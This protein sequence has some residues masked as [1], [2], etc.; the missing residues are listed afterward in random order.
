MAKKRDR[1][2]FALT[3]SATAM[4]G[5]VVFYLFFVVQMVNAPDA[6]DGA[7]LLDFSAFWGAARLA[8]DGL[9]PAAYDFRLIQIA[10][11]VPPDST[12]Q[13]PWLYPPTAFLAVLPLGLLPFSAGFG[14]FV[15][16]SLTVW[17]RTMA[18]LGRG[19]RAGLLFVFATPTFAA[20]HIIGNNPA[21]WIGGLVFALL[22]LR[23]GRERSA[24][25][26]LAAMTLK[27]S[28]GLLIPVA[29]IAAGAWRAV[30]WA[31]GGALFLAAA[32]TAI[33]GVE[34][35]GAF[36]DTLALTQELLS[37]DAF[38]NGKMTTWHAAL[39]VL[40]A[41]A[42]TAAAAQ[43]AVTLALAGVVA[44]AWR[45]PG[46]CFD[47]RCALLLFAIPLSGPY[48]FHYETLAAIPGLVFLARAQGLATLE[49]RVFAVLVWVGLVPFLR[50][51]YPIAPY[52]AALMTAGVLLSLRAAV[53]SQAACAGPS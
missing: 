11:E 26:V 10:Q 32:A 5:A 27:P 53:R 25:L 19:T 49:E 30:G 43:A 28:L 42:A 48:A 23:D 36:L 4:I 37:T 51:G 16:V 1:L 33:F 21:L 34:S 31:A 38:D 24:G 3:I 29:L 6:E 22:A 9:A 40:G 12:R 15:L 41:P 17:Y 52:G 13:M 8:L 50:A 20:V 7:I 47:S 45:M 2:V 14:L 39:I 46:V 35:W 44:Y 18:P